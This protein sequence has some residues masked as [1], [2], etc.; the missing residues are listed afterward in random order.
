MTLHSAN[1]F[2]TMS[3]DGFEVDIEKAPR[4]TLHPETVIISL[5]VFASYMNACWLL[6]SII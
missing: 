4:R 1:F 3:A 6:T 2:S 5:L